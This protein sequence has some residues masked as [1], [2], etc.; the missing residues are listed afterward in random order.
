MTSNNQTAFIK[1][2]CI[3]D[4]FFFVRQVVK[5]K[6]RRKFPSLFIELDISKAFDTLNRPYL[7]EIMST[8]ALAKDGGT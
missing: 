7:L 8:Y 5:D 4:N 2:R 3:H 1:T 6:H